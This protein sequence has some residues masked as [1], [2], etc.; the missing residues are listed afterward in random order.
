MVAREIR[1]SVFVSR[2][3]YGD[4]SFLFCCWT[5]RYA[6]SEET[7]DE[8][9]EEGIS[10]TSSAVTVSGDLVSKRECQN[11]LGEALEEDKRE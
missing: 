3:K 11:G 2:R 7:G 9:D 8:F 10:L 5:C 1:T 4:I 6:Y